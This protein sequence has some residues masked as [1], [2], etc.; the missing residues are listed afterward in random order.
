M[1]IAAG[2]AAT[3]Y[4]LVLVIGSTSVVGIASVAAATVAVPAIAFGSV[5]WG[6]SGLFRSK[7]QQ[8]PGKLGTLP[9]AVLAGATLV[10]LGLLA[11]AHFTVKPGPAAVG[12]LFIAFAI[13]AALLSKE[14]G[15]LRK[16]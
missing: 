15:D 12:F 10:G 9:T 13:E 7:S 5:L 6:P 14:Y 8:L 16:H 11:F 1:M 3:A 2:I 4:V